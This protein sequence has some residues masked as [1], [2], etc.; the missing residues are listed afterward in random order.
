MSHQVQKK[1]VI[2]NKNR[3]MG[4]EAD[5]EWQGSGRYHLLDSSNPDLKHNLVSRLG[6]RTK[7]SP[8]LRRPR[9]YAWTNGETPTGGAWPGEANK[10]RTKRNQPY[11]NR[12]NGISRHETWKVAAVPDTT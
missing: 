6:R 2:T 8:R 11:S 9:N 10:M 3:K 5:A 4:D 1:H 12:T 7:Q